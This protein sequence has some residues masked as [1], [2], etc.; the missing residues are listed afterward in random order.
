MKPVL[1]TPHFTVRPMVR[2]DAHGKLQPWFA[3]LETMFPLNLP[4][5]L[6]PIP[7]L[8]ACT[9]GF[10]GEHAR[11]RR[12]A[13][14]VAGEE[15]HREHASR[16]PQGTPL[17]EVRGVPSGKGYCAMR[18]RSRRVAASV[19][20]FTGSAFHPS[21]A[22]DTPTHSEAAGDDAHASLTTLLEW[23]PF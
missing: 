3:D 15:M 6:V 10:D 19:S 11:S 5:R 7:E 22:R 2:A 21:P 20:M 12:L 1:V 4:K 17:D 23:P 9:E 13:N 8:I 18:Y 14:R 16:E